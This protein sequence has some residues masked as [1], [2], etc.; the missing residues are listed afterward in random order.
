MLPL[1]A[2]PF[3]ANT[4]N[5]LRFPNSDGILPEIG[6]NESSNFLRLF[7][8]PKVAGKVPFKLLKSR[9]I[10]TT[11][12]FSTVIPCHVS[13]GFS[14]S[15]VEFH[16]GPLVAVYRFKRTCFSWLLTCAKTIDEINIH[17]Q[18]SIALFIVWGY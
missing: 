13:T 16:S 7:S 14:I 3:I 8:C 4:S 11:L 10:A 1:K 18:L 5:V 12:L 6:L 9:L 17:I 2:V 15:Q